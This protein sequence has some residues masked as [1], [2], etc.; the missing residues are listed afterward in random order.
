M[1][2]AATQ[3]RAQTS[4]GKQSEKKG[5]MKHPFTTIEDHLNSFLYK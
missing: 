1:F 5:W 3:K 2:V 4:D